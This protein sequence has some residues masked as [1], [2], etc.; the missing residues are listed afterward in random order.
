M[1]TT[2]IPQLDICFVLGTSFMEIFLAFILF[3]WYL[4]ATAGITTQEDYVDS[5]TSTCSARLQPDAVRAR[6]EIFGPVISIIAY[7]ELTEASQI[8]NDSPYGLSGSVWTNET[9]DWMWRD[10]IRTGVFSVNGAGTRFPRTIWR[11]QAGQ[12]RT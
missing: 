1:L 6:E 4:Q 5:D 11:F 7:D 3:F 9:R 10:A 2:S 12:T 8:R